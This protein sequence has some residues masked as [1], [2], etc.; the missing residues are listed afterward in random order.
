MIE[1]LNNRVI[2][3]VSGKDAFKLLQ[4]LITQNLSNKNLIYS[5]MLNT[6]GKYLFDFFVYT[7][8]EN[9]Y[10]IDLTKEDVVDFINRLKLFKLRAD[11]QISINDKYHV[12]YSN[13]PLNINNNIYSRDPRFEKLGIR[14]LVPIDQNLADYQISHNLYLDDKYKYTIPDGCIDLTKD[15]S[16]PIEYGAEELAAIS[17]VK[18]CY[19]GQ[20]V[21][22]RTKYQGVIRKKLF[23]LI[24]EISLS[25]IDKGAEIVN[26]ENGSV[27]QIGILCSRHKNQ[28]IALIREEYS[29]HT[30][31]INNIPLTIETPSWRKDA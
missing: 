13:D 27:K 10:L 5:Y 15:K 24:A 6:Q 26:R 17:Y 22:S 21:I 25:S 23:K 30:A 2:I 18:G 14:S 12:I 16:F 1:I 4:N 28:G 19:M 11:V 7:I 3:E 9:Q 20:E 31:Y 29:M 8:T